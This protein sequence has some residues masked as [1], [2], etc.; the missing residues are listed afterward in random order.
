MKDLLLEIG[1]EE[2]P[3]G[4]LND[5]LIGIKEKFLVLLEENLIEVGEINVYATPRRISVLVENVAE[6]Q[7]VKMVSIQ[8]PPVKVAYKDGKPTRALESFLEKNSLTLENIK[9]IDTPR[10]EYVKADK[11]VGGK[12]V[13]PLLKELLEEFIK[14]IHFPKSMRWNATGVTFAR[15][16][17]WL[18]ALWG[19]EI[20]PLEYAGVK[21]GNITKGHRFLSGNVEIIAPVN[22][23]ELLLKNMVMVDQENRKSI[24]VNQL[25]ELANKVEGKIPSNEELLSE[26]TYLVEYPVV[27][28]GKINEKFLDLPDEVIITSAQHHQKYFTAVDQNGKLLPYFFTVS[29]MPVADTSLIVKGNERV[30]KSRLEDAEFFFREDLKKPLESLLEKLKG[31]TYQKK[32]GSVYDKIIRDLKIGQVIAEDLNWMNIWEKIERTIKLSKCD[33][34]TNMVYEFPELQGIMGKEYALRQGEDND[35]AIGIF[36]HY[37]PRFSDDRLP[38][39]KTGIVASI[40]DK[41][42]TVVSG[43]AVGLKIS[44]GQ[45]PFGLRRAAIGILQIILGKDLYLNLSRG[46]DA[47]IESVEEQGIKSKATADDI[48]EFFKVRFENIVGEYGYRRDLVRAVIDEDFSK[49]VVALKKIKAIAEFL[50]DPSFKDLSVVYKRVLNIL[51]NKEPD[52]EIFSPNLLIEQSERNLWEAFEDF[53]QVFEQYLEKMSFREAMESILHLKPVID[54]FFDDVLVMAEDEKLRNNRLALLT[55]INMEIRKLADFSKI[56]F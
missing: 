51:K 53:K 49:P 8:G 6:K 21:A 37:L 46:I 10:G 18:V 25:K 52:L 38:E 11:E 30:L 42:D 44:G 39:R 24:I 45:D 19:N 7:K 16:I 28:M 4:F 17:R 3:A 1:T 33:L 5:L 43:F 32:L 31:V 40:A 34:L 47:A 48:E 55:F 54:K 29:N 12:D 13:F 2:I 35:I 50:E 15:P 20:I 22:Y 26:V 36:E 9:V 27:L 41:L 56:T 14:S 23:K